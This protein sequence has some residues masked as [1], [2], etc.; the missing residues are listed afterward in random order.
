M[1]RTISLAVL[2]S[3]LAAPG[4]VFAGGDP[5][6]EG[7]LASTTHTV[8][9]PGRPLWSLSGTQVERV[10]SP[11]WKL[12]DKAESEPRVSFEYGTELRT[13]ERTT[14]GQG[15]FTFPGFNA[16]FFLRHFMNSF[17]FGGDHRMLGS[18]RL[19]GEGGINTGGLFVFDSRQGFTFVGGIHSPETLP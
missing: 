8:T 14:Q 5:L 9:E 10:E 6:V 16:P 12:A 11:F 4:A 13:V 19:G 18:G 1:L 17:G 3:C 15:P 2:L 7:A